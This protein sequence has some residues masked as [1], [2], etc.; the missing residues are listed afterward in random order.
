MAKHMCELSQSVKK[1]F[2]KIAQL[3][4]QPRFLCTDCGRVADQKKRLC[5]PKR[6][7]PLGRAPA[8]ARPSK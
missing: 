2:D 5:E 7:P 8:D 4:E 6:I 1:N 3:V